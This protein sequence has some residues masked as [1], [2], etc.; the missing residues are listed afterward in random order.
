MTLNE[1]NRIV[2]GRC[3]VYVGT[4]VT[5]SVPVGARRGRY[6]PTGLL[7]PDPIVPGFGLFHSRAEWMYVEFVHICRQVDED[8]LYH[9]FVPPSYTAREFALRVL[10]T[11]TLHPRAERRLV[12]THQQYVLSLA[13]Y[14]HSL[15]VAPGH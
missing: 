5:S 1:A 15:I 2:T 3:P 13:Q 12:Y 9:Y 6:Y 11:R 10:R 8:A 7:A 14:R 4:V